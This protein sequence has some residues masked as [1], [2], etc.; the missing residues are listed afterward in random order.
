[1]QIS[2]ANACYTSCRPRYTRL[3]SEQRRDNHTWYQQSQNMPSDYP[4]DSH[5]PAGNVTNGC[6]R[7]GNLLDAACGVH[8]LDNIF[9][10][11]GLTDHS[12][13]FDMGKG[14]VGVDNS[15]AHLPVRVHCGVSMLCVVRRTSVKLL[16]TTIFRPS[17]QSRSEP[18]TLGDPAT[19]C[20]PSA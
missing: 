17:F 6:G 12:R 15:F 16:C 2:M 5:K 20:S 11:D 7:Q 8:L 4:H 14:G 13:R 18:F 19:P 9:A 3:V 10:A 1:M